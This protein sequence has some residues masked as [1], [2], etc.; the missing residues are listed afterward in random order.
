MTPTFLRLPLTAILCALPIAAHADSVSQ[1][2]TLDP[3]DDSLP[4]IP[5]LASDD[6]DLATL[7]E[8]N[9][10]DGT[11]LATVSAGWTADALHLRILVY[12]PEHVTA[13][14]ARSLW[15]ADSIELG[16]DAA[17]D[18]SADRPADTG[19]P[20]GSDDFKLIFGLLETGPAVNSLT[21]QTAP[22]LTVLGD[23][24]TI[25][26]TPS[27]QTLYDITL[28]WTQLNV[29]GGTRPTLGLDLQINDLNPDA[30]DKTAY[31]WGTGL[32]KGFTAAQLKA[33]TLAAP[34]SSL[35]VLQWDNPLAWDDSTPLVLRVGLRS[36]D[37]TPL[38]VTFGDQNETLELP[39]GPGLRHHVITLPAQPDGTALS[40]S[41][42][43]VPTVATTQIQASAIF[44]KLQDR[45][46]ALIARPDQPPL[47]TRHLQSIADLTADDWARTQSIRTSDPNR[48]L[49]S[50]AHYRDLLNGLD[51]DTADWS[52]YLD[53]RRSL[54][55]AYTS[56]HDQTLQYYL[57]S[58][59]RDWDPD[60]AYPLFFELH[61]AGND[62]P[63]ASFSDRLSAKAKRQDGYGYESPKVYGEIERSGYWVHPFGRGN[64]SYQGDA[65]IDVLEAY[66]HAHELF[67][68]DPDRRYLYGFSMGG[69]GTLTLG[70]RT[71]SRWAAACS[72]AASSRNGE[73]H[74]P[75]SANWSLL[76]YKLM[77]GEEDR[78]FKSYQDIVAGLAKHDIHPEARSIPGLGHQ[79]LGEL[80]KEK[81]E[82]LKTHVRT[83]PDT[84]TFVTDDNLTN[85]CWGITLLVPEGADERA[86]VTYRRDEQTLHLATEGTAQVTID[87]SEPDG[88][89]VTGDISVLWNDREAYAGPAQKITLEQ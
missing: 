2:T 23:H 47:F 9:R 60:R 13:R 74:S 15:S 43:D 64:K 14:D 66:D 45:L 38:T 5:W 25:T 30:T 26:R 32:S 50:L 48:A 31:P 49:E 19:G 28:P 70:A 3:A 89:G 62:H 44:Q 33:F 8:I 61:G 79:Y 1:L 59:P 7:G 22:D 67:K 4:S 18:G 76:P 87:P 17:G 12:D 20:I 82:W 16:I 69:L 21:A 68:I 10:P 80:Q 6:A 34:P 56:E 73:A 37:A 72:I 83:R 27:H 54:V 88:L 84:F 52:A 63:M 41:L 46:A 55:I 85:T 11:L 75:V 71:P 36:D 35:S 53:G 86:R 29:T 39:G 42:P 24:L 57:L 77:V 58:L 51:A 81:I 40:A 78:F 65:R